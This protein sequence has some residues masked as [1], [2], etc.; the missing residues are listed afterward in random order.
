MKGVV[1]FFARINERNYAVK[2][3][4][5]FGSR[6][7]DNSSWEK[8]KMVR[9]LQTVGWESK[10]PFTEL[11][12]LKNAVDTVEGRHYYLQK[13]DMSANNQIAVQSHWLLRPEG[14]HGKYF[15]LNDA[16]VT[17]VSAKSLW[18]VNSYLRLSMASEKK[19][20][21]IHAKKMVLKKKMPSSTNPRCPYSEWCALGYQQGEVL[22]H[23][24]LTVPVR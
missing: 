24:L 7:F 21:W 22:T 18:Q 14:K 9:P 19:V 20:Y 17:I 3:I 13:E 23:K 1:N 12:S 10:R 15:T 2:A 5:S 16:V 4:A 11:Y 6:Q 8:G